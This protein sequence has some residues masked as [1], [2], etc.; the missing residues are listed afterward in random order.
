MGFYLQP[1]EP[2]ADAIA[3]IIGELLDKAHHELKK[4]HSGRDAAIH[5]VRKSMKKLRALLRLIRPVVRKKHFRAADKAVRD[6]SRRLG[7]ARDST[8]VLAT[9]DALLAYYSD[10]LNNRTVDPIRE[11]LAKRQWL[12]MEQHLAAMDS[13]SLMR[14]L[15]KLEQCFSC[16]D[17]GQFTC[18]T[19]LDSA[20][21]SYR[22]GRTALAALHVDPSTEHG[23]AL[24]KHV[25]Y[26]W[27]QMRLLQKADTAMIRQLILELDEL[28][29]LLG[30]DHDLALLGDTLKGAPG[31]CCNAVRC[32]LIGGLIETRRIALLSAALRLADRVFTAEPKRLLSELKADVA[33]L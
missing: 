18:E 6:F 33:R 23:H 19:L 1:E 4:P 25:K 9:F 31:I 16:L 8:V 24:R 5:E 30:Q 21:Q 13:D 29:E 12:A 26:L 11:S 32:E 7:G 3:R 15:E 22:E 28:G 14:D 20:K 2:A 10:Y 17:L 27:Y